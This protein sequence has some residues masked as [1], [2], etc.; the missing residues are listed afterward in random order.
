[1]AKKSLKEISKKMRSLDVCMMSTG[2]GSAVVSRPMST[3]GDVEYDGNSYF[4]TWEDSKL[5]KDLKKKPAVNLAFHGKRDLFVSVTGKAKVVRD[6]A[7][8]EEHWV[9]SLDAWF[10]DGPQ[11]EGVVMLVVA[12]KRVTYWQ[13]EEMGEFKS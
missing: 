3:N 11:T 5:V 1:M 10:K 13:R 2:S 7:K 6:Q 12:A 4:F 8:F 9:K